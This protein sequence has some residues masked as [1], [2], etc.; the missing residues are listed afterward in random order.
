MKLSESLHRLIRPARL[1][2]EGKPWK[3]LVLFAL[4]IF[5]SQLFQQLYNTADSFIV[6]NYIGYEALAAV[7]S[8]GN[9]IYLL[10]SFFVGASMG[11][12]VVI[13]RHFGAGDPERVSRAVHTNIVFSLICGAVLTVF[14]VTMTPTILHWMGVPETVMPK[15][16]A[17]LRYYFLGAIPLVMYNSMKGIMNAVGDS[18][19][20]LI[21]LIVSS[22]I[23]VLLDWLFIAVFGL[24][25]EWAAIATVASQTVSAILCLVQLCRKGTVYQ[26][27]WKKL[28]MDRESFREIVRYGLPTGV[29]NSVIGLA[30]VL[31]QTNINS[32]DADAMAA[33]GAYSRV[34]GFVFLPIMS[35]SMALTSFIGQNLGAKQYDRAKQGA[36]FGILASIIMAEVVGLVL[37]FFGGWIIS[38]FISNETPEAIGRIIAIGSLQS[39]VESLFFF[40]LAFSLSLIHI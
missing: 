15:S 24:G 34:E 11:A 39:R 3:T 9:L 37:F 7:N 31:V 32:F 20:P 38:G 25:V 13:S 23:N 35:F 30:N 16:V 40:L 26:L 27:Q 22:L 1:L 12:G 2:T 36:R 17:Y 18:V 14:G 4:P 29:Q 8:T 28:R 19:R 5:L 33:C 10:I 21:Y 6:G